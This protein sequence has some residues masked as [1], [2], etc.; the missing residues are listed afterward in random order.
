[1]EE[2]NDTYIPVQCLDIVAR[3]SIPFDLYVNLPRNQKLFLYRRA[4]DVLE[5]Q[6]L[7]KI[8][9][10]SFTHFYV[11][12][13]QY[14]HFVD[15]VALQFR[16][17]LETSNESKQSRRL[18]QAARGMLSSTF[19][20]DNSAIAAVL[21]ENLN[22]ITAALIE[23][24]LEGAAYRQA[25]QMFQRLAQLA[26]K[27]TDF[28]RHPITVTSLA[29]LI[30]L[31]VG[32]SN[33]HILNDL[34]MAA[35]LH[36]IGLSQ[37]STKIIQKSHRPQDLSP[38]ESLQLRRHPMLALEVLRERGVEISE[39]TKIIISQHHEDFA[40]K[41]YPLGIRGYHFNELA[42]IVRLAD[43][44]DRV[45]GDL[46]ESRGRGAGILR[47]SLQEMFDQ[48]YSNRVLEPELLVRVRSMV[49]V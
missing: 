4:N 5:S 2:L 32:Y 39:L 10:Q 8:S 12:K 40:G 49:G 25:K 3:S 26:E 44:I 41:G 20:Q 46:Q 22:N 6:R 13:D 24:S 45:F 21:L 48:L 34:A 28:H 33:E 14:D 17:L 31:A 23:A 47:K 18:S 16:S 27:G 9:H 19:R 1:M 29:V 7:Q 35:L 42:Q 11:H 43:E 30:S 15:Y 37:L 36:D 38:L